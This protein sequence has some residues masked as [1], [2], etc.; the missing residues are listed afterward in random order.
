VSLTL[1]GGVA[2]AE[3]MWGPVGGPLW[4]AHDPSKNVTKLKG[5]GVYAVAAGGAQGDVDRLA[6]GIANFTG[7]LIESIVL[8]NTQKFADAAAAAGVPINFVIRPEGSHTWGAVR[9]GGAGVVEH[10]DRSGAGSSLGPVRGVRAAAVVGV[11]R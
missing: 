7:G 5:V 1:G 4:I 8:A 2:S 10:H 11:D 3:A 9:V 6:P